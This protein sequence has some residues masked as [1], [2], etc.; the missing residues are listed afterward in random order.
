[1]HTPRGADWH[2]LSS[3]GLEEPCAVIT[4]P[5]KVSCTIS[6]ATTTP[7]SPV[8][9]AG[10]AANGLE[11]R[12]RTVGRVLGQLDVYWAFVV[13]TPVA[14]NVCI[15]AAHAIADRACAWPAGSSVGYLAGHEQVL[16][17]RTGPR[18]HGLAKMEPETPDDLDAV[19]YK[20]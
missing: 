20:S 9:L 16:Q 17:R 12:G 1:M 19:P 14:P 5:L 13:L 8:P 2:R 10:L 4:Q 18:T 7:L 3:H 15:A 6:P 11:P